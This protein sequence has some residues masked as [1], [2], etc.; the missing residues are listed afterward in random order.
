[1]N[2]LNHNHKCAGIF[3]DLSKAFDCVNHKILIDKLQYYGIRGSVLNLLRSYLT[4]R[5]QYVQ[6]TKVHTSGYVE[7]IDS[8]EKNTYCGVPQG[9]VLGPLLFLIFINDLP[10]NIKHGKLYLYADDTSIILQNHDI[11][12]LKT[13]ISETWNELLH[14]FCCNGLRMNIDK[15]NYIT[16]CRHTNSLTYDLP[17]PIAKVENTKFLGV[18]LDAQL[19]WLTHVD[20]LRKRLA[21][22]CYTLNY[23]SKML[24]KS[25]LKTV[26]YA[27][28]ESLLKYC[29]EVWGS[30]VHVNAILILQKKAVRCIE[31]AKPRD[32][33]RP[34]F[35][36]HQILTVISLYIYLIAIM[37][38]KNKSNYKCK[39]QNRK[40]ALRNN[41]DL[42]LPKCNNYVHYKRS[43]EYNGI[44][45]YNCLNADIKQCE[46]LNVFKRKLKSYL[47]TRPFYSFNEFFEKIY[48]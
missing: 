20:T 11:S 42:E 32:H 3:C 27:Y 26:Y 15:T 38:H 33:C 31:K 13:Q 46:E 9:S 37:I 6:I 22:A 35:I 40:H 28:F 34:L 2:S 41:N 48:D 7:Y 16:F 5:T 30:S 12:T 29:L 47:L 43:P 45:I 25:G 1:M 18:Q 23:L 17:L 4:C 21:S 24:N 19:R 8:E 14:W 10:K 39:G 36:K 44:K